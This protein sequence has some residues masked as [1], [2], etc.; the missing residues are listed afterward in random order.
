MADDVIASIK[1]PAVAQARQELARS[2]DEASFFLVDGLRLTAQALEAGADIERMFFLHPVQDE[3][4]TLLERARQAGVECHT[5]SKGVFFKVLGL[6]YETSVR[7]LALVKRPPSAGLTGVPGADACWLVGECIQDPRNVGVLIRTADGWAGT[8]AVFS[9]NSADPYARASVRSST[10]SVFRV[11]VS[12][13]ARLAP[14][15]KALKADAVRIIGSSAGAET[16]C[17]DADLTGRC[18]LVL[19]NESTGLSDEVREACD[20][21][22]TVPMGG[23]AHSFNVTVAAGILLYERARQSGPSASVKTGGCRW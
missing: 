7:V 4:A 3:T 19:G 13:P 1:H 12:L 15:L 5:A 9:A 23:G 22:V 20:A 16:P 11:P 6:G 21:L 2:R 17:W 8:R 18:A 10:G 14:C